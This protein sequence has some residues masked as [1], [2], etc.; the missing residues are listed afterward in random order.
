MHVQP[1]QAAN[2]IYLE[3]ANAA[4]SVGDLHFACVNRII[5]CN[6]ALWVGNDL[7]SVSEVILRSDILP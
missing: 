4:M 7:C 2:E 6:N 5:Y 1:S 3:G